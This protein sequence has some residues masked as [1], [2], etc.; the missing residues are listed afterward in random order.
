MWV[1]NDRWAR[2]LL[3]LSVSTAAWIGCDNQGEPTPNTG[4]TGGV[5]T[6]GGVGGA[7]GGAGGKGG[8][9]GV[10][11]TGGR[12]GAGGSVGGS[13]GAEGGKGGAGGSVVA[14]TG[15]AGDGGSG[16]EGGAGESGSGGVGGLGGSGGGN[17]GGET[18]SC[19]SSTGGE[20]GSENAS[21]GGGDTPL[22]MPA[23]DGDAVCE[24]T[25]TYALKMT[26][27]LRWTGGAVMDPGC[28]DAEF[29]VLVDLE[30]DGD[31][32]TGSS[33]ICSIRVPWYQADARGYEA[34]FGNLESVPA[35]RVTGTHCASGG[36][37]FFEL[38][39]FAIT[40][41]VRLPNPVA[42][43]WPTDPNALVLRDD[44]TDGLPAFTVHGGYDTEAWPFPVDASGSISSQR[45]F[46]GARI[47]VAGVFPTP[48]CSTAS[49][50]G[51]VLAF[52]T[53]VLGCTLC[54]GS[55]WNNC[56]ELDQRC[57]PEQT[58]YLDAWLLKYDFAGASMTLT[59]RFQGAG[60]IDFGP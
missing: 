41:G 44:D 46:V 50:T 40:L 45:V 21:E 56:S 58:A 42:D 33:E 38:G 51:R 31:S 9:G 11:G 5:T 25:G 20:G 57:T 30:E 4:A 22:S 52:D 7:K 27:P 24:M 48:R 1:T 18:F 54:T 34:D 28:N 55:S 6:T 49:T 13:V 47:A 32:V 39:P 60:C 16:A 59:R 14:G 36:S 29:R 43:A 35:A 17:Y 10:G 37:D 19:S 53:S 15:G 2:S 26:V 12:G 8:R 23:C 3:G